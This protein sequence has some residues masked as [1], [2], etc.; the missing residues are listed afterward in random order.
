[1]ATQRRSSNSETQTREASTGRKITA[2]QYSLLESD[3]EWI[4]DNLLK[5]YSHL[6]FETARRK[7]VKTVNNE[8][9][10]DAEGNAIEAVVTNPISM[11]VLVRNLVNYMVETTLKE[12]VVDRD[13]GN[14]SHRINPDVATLFDEFVETNSG[15]IVDETAKYQASLMTIVNKSSETLDEFELDILAKLREYQASKLS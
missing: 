6:R 9:I 7:K 3:A 12:K 4:S 10:V 14:V 11:Q 8:T 2:G 1:M 13:S 15:A 5:R